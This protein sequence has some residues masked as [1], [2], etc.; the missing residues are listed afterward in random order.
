MIDIMIAFLVQNHSSITQEIGFSRKCFQKE[1][2]LL[3]LTK[4]KAQVILLL[5]KQFQVLE[6]AKFEF[7]VTV[8]CGLRQNA[9][10]CDPLGQKLWRLVPTYS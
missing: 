2:Q 5:L 6:I 9:S 8:Q 1:Q 3:F 10:S 7:T 4:L